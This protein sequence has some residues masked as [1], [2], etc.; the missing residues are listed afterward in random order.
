MEAAAGKA[1]ADLE[2][3]ISEAQASFRQ[4]HKELKAVQD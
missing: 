1:E 3:R 2:E 4:A